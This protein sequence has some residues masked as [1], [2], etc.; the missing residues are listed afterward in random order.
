MRHPIIHQLGNVDES[1]DA[2]LDPGECSKVCE[3]RHG[4]ANKLSDL[5]GG[6]YT[7]PR[8]S[9]GALDRKSDLL[10]LSVD[11]QDVDVD[12]LA[13]SQHF[14]RMPHP[15]PGKLGEMDQSVSSA[16]V[17]EGAEV[18]DRGDAAL[19]DFT[20]TQFIDQPLLHH[21]SPLLHRLALREDESVSVTIDFDH[22]QRQ[23]ATDQSCHVGLLAGLVAAPD[24]G[25][26]RRRNEAAH[27]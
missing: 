19:A 13:H 6:R 10:F 11:T 25:Y 12:F 22:L 14:A 2:V 15:A 7:A 3:L 1:L 16:Y 23:G 24:L 9:L 20:L 4:A 18:A 5:V 21:V 26:L 17:D 27:A 8:L